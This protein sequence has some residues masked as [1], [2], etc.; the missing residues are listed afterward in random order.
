M[1]DDQRHKFGMRMIPK[2]SKIINSFKM[3][4]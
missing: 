4:C 1:P 3:I 2:I